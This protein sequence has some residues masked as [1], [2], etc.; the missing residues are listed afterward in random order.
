MIGIQSPLWDLYTFEWLDFINLEKSQD[1]HAR[2]VTREAA[3]NIHSELL[4]GVVH[5][6]NYD[7]RRTVLYNLALEAYDP[8]AP[9]ILEHFY[10]LARVIAHNSMT[11]LNWKM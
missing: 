4:S 8:I 11:S 2:S 5:Q 3:H 7:A 1:P 9:I 10:S 6:G